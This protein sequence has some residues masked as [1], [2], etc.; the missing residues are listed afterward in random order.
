MEYGAQA[1]SRSMTTTQLSLMFP[2]RTLWFFVRAGRRVVRENWEI[3]P[4]ADTAVALS[5][6]PSGEQR[7][8]SEWGHRVMMNADPRL[9]AKRQKSCC[10]DDRPANL[11][12]YELVLAE[13][14]EELV[15]VH[16]GEEA[17]EQV[18]SEDFAVILLDVNMPGLGGFETAR[19]IRANPRTAPICR[20]F[21]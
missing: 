4:E 11:L 19:R 8:K 20:S 7:P 15:M 6:L 5:P 18:E 12:V 17:L 10:V 16:S 9:A 3:G 2:D 21:S 14:N 1:F 13:L